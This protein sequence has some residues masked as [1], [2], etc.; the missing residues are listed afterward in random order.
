MRVSREIKK[1]LYFGLIAVSAVSLTLFLIFFLFNKWEKKLIN[2]RKYIC[3]NYAGHLTIEIEENDT[4][5]ELLSLFLNDS[6]ISVADSKNIENEF[7]RI[8]EDHVKEVKGLEG[9]V[10]LK[11]M[12]DFLGYAYPTSLPP[13]PVY[14]PPPRSYN[15]IKLQSMESINKD[16]AFSDLHAFDPAVFPL[17]TSPFRINGQVA[18]SV[19][20]RIHIERELPIAKL[21]RLINL[22][23]IISLVGFVLM[24][25]FTFFMSNGIKNIRRE[26]D[27]TRKNPGYRLKQRGGWFGFIPASIN[28][29]L[30]LIEKEYHQ[31][32]ELEKELQQKEK[33]ASLGKLIAGVAHEVKTPL[34]VI[35]MRVQMWQKHVL[36]NSDFQDKIEP[37]S[38]NL[39]LDEINRLSALVKRLVVFSRPIYKNLAPTNI[40]E[41][42]DE[43]LSL[44]EFKEDGKMISIQKHFITAP[45]LIKADSNSLK[46]VF[47]NLLNNAKESI[48]TEGEIIIHS[49]TNNNEDKLIIEILDNGVGIS[50]EIVNV[51][52]DPFF[53]TKEH[54][55]GLGL[56]ISNEI[57]IAHGGNIFFEKNQGNGTKCIITLPVQ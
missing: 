13:I 38:I 16:S 34:A 33:L 2:S 10:F 15:I 28:Q 48:R 14:G 4:L 55:T 42:I 39:V 47:I 18:G 32:Q 22:I 44:I 1:L 46:Q 37:E 56:S 6:S 23:T 40:D 35:K 53:T 43:V 5:Q 11:E 54:G 57:I 12:D 8:I 21:K 24:A 29:M 20:V 19:W 25:I 17:A 50:D 36:D 52:F 9:G 31:R 7:T 45:P 51:I 49:R 27:N 3:E 41:V 30:N 26:L